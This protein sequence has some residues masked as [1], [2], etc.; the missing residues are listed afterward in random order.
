MISTSTSPALGPSSSNSTIS[1]GCLGAK[2]TAAQVFI[3]L[4]LPERCGAYA[5]KNRL[6]QPAT[7]ALSLGALSEAIAA[8]GSG[9]IS[10]RST[11]SAWANAGANSGWNWNEIAGRSVQASAANGVK[12]DS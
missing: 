7:R 11:I 2:A 4:T 9:T 12:A 6:I 1:S 3:V 5:R 10:Y 8:S